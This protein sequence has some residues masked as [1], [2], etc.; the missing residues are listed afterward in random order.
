MVV[1]GA[2]RGAGRGIALTLGETGATV[3]VTGRGGTGIPVICDHRHDED[4]RRYDAARVD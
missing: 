3:Y 4:V 2:G 1:T